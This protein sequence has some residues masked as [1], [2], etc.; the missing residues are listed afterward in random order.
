M[1]KSVKIQRTYNNTK[2]KVL[3][4][5]GKL[6]SISWVPVCLISKTIPLPEI[7]KTWVEL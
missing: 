4:I 1:S 2:R 3:D 5:K 7:R 6:E